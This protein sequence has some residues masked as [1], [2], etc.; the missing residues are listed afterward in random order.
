M[1]LVGDVRSVSA[2]PLEF[3]SVAVVAGEMTVSSL[4]TLETLSRVFELMVVDCARHQP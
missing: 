4:C 2:L 3:N 1:V